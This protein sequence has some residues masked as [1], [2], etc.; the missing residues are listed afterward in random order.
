MS[1]YFL[2]VRNP[3]ADVGDTALGTAGGPTCVREYKKSD[4]DAVLELAP[5]LCYAVA[6][7]R[8]R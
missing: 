7:W 2:R 6:P 3:C 8:D 5:Y 4:A 1:R